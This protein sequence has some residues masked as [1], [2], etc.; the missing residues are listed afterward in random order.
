M[1]VDWILNFDYFRGN[2]VKVTRMLPL[3]LAPYGPAWAGWSLRPWG[4]A[5]DAR[6]TAPDSTS[7]TSGEIIECC[8]LPAD[9]DFLRLRVRELEAG[10]LDARQRVAVIAAIQVLE[11]VLLGCSSSSV[12]EGLGRPVPF[13]EGL[14]TL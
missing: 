12:R 13:I 1:S 6:L 7:Y 8:A 3:D 11:A 14:R 2:S 10:G 9:V 4:R 5:R